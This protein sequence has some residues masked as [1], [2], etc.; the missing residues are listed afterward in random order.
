MAD[1]QFSL[2]RNLSMEKIKKIKIAV[3]GGI[4]SGKSLFCN[5]LNQLGIPVISVD[6]VSKEL[7][8]TDKDIRGKII[9]AFGSE[10]FNGNIANK[11]YLA[12]KVFSNPLNVI[13]INSIIHPKVIKKVNILADEKLRSANIVAAE[14]ALIYEADME[15]YFDYVVLVT[16]DINLR[17]KRKV[18]KENYTEEQ[19]YKRNEN[20]IPDDEKKKRADFVFENN[21]SLEDLQTKAFLLTNILKGLSIENV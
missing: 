19:F 6:E 16:S 15:K 12:E 7:L 4:G 14:A 1:L 18:E 9:K 11:K 2:N 17:I 13:T 20:Q 8:E 3:T 5:F 21:G 10:S